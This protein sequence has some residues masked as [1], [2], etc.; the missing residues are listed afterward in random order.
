MD[1]YQTQSAGDL[2][3]Y[4]AILARRKW[5]ILPFIVLIP[6]VTYI[7]TSGEVPVY[8]ASSE[9][10]L[11]RQ[12]TSLSGLADPN[13][14]TPDR[15]IRT[16]LQVARLPAIADL[17]VKAAKLTDR[18]A[19][20]FLAQS[21]VDASDQLD[22]MTFNV[23]DTNAALASTLA[24]LYAQK[25]IGY[26]ASIDTK[27]YREAAAALAVQ[28]QKMNRHGQGGSALAASLIERRQQLVTAE[29]LESSNALL[30]RPAGGAGQTSPQP[31]RSTILALLLGI[32]LGLGIAFLIDTLDTRLRSEVDLAS[33]LG[34]PLLTSVPA[35][36]RE[37][38]RTPTVVMLTDPNS[39]DAEAY[40]LLRT[41][42][43]VGDGHDCQMV[44]VTSGIAAEG[45]ST[46]AA[47]FAVANARAGRHV[48]LVDLDLRRPSLGRFFALSTQRGITDLVVGDRNIDQVATK[49]TF[50]QATS[51]A[52]ARSHVSGRAPRTKAAALQ[53][54][55]TGASAN[56]H[57][58]AAGLLEVI[59]SGTEVSNPGEFF[60]TPEL[61]VVFER[62]RA[63]ASLIVIDAPPLLL[64]GEA[65][66]LSA[67]VDGMLVVSRVNMLRRDHVRQLRQTLAAAPALTIGLVVTG[68][69]RHP[70]SAYYGIETRPH[71]PDRHPV[72]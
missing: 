72:A 33:A 31:T 17:V 45:K 9:V 11:N 19:G 29:T 36:P 8:R 4:L 25:Y 24:T 38:R 42:I 67:K 57:A 46:V 62:L 21:S 5:I 43:D 50:D 59:G 35:S 23:N 63:R 37:L 26:R 16:Q 53:P 69:P 48:V 14:S 40:R 44:M 52:G 7:R 34:L 32:V 20:S 56:G 47:N 39:S 70:E 60:T 27:A 15:T 10:L 13:G 22:V 3:S 61:D 71:H 51:L 28:I 1:A 65:L 30:I 49:L 2:R 12:T 6:L 41:S 68:V 58:A 66:T 64:A 18:G 55:V 54:R